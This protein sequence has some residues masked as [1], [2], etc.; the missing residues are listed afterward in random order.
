MHAIT[1]SGGVAEHDTAPAA[2]LPRRKPLGT[3][4]DEVP[5]ESHPFAQTHPDRLATVATLFGMRPAPIDRCRVLELGCAGGGNLIPMALALPNSHFLGIDLSPRQIAEGQKVVSALGLDNIELRHLSILDVGAETGLFDY[6]LC[7]GVYSWVPA[8]VQDKI[9]EVCSQNLAPGGVAY[10]SYNT[11]PGWHMSGLIRDMMC[12]HARRYSLPQARAGQSRALLDFL[13]GA[14]AHQ[15]SAYSS[16]LREGVEL[17][18]K[19]SD[20]YLLHEYLEAVNDPL[21]FHEFME[22]ATARGLQ[23]LGEAQFSAMVPD[24]FPREVADT[25]KQLSSDLIEMEQFMDFLRNRRFRQTLLCHQDV[26]LQRNLGPASL[27]DLSLASP[28]RPVSAT[29]DVRSEAPE[30]FRGSGD[31]TT[32]TANPLVKAA[33]LHLAE[34]WPRAVPF[35]ALRS[36]ARAR[37]GMTAEQDAAGV[38]QD[39]RALGLNFLHLYTANLVELHVHCLPFELEP[40]ERPLASPLARHQ[41]TAGT[42]V[43]NLR[44]EWVRLNPFDCQVLRHLDGSRGRAALLDVLTR[45]AKEGLLTVHQKGQPVPDPGEVRRVLGQTLDQSLLRLARNALLMG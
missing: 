22:R 36:A 14:V 13:A 12:Y 31:G 15:P 44:H 18:R 37:L 41:A 42:A 38:A 45:L 32:S 34:C 8:A 2:T 25:L 7:H 10:V 43:T 33:L 23:Y 16:L 19:G 29:P 4:Y 20:S 3:S 27:A 17:L 24:K 9:L 30:E 6:I 1:N 28:L 40:G 21:Y 39:T 5:Y 11:Y 35:A 26:P